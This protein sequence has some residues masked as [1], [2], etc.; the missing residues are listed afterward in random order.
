MNYQ[1]TDSGLAEA[2]PAVA[3]I[4]DPGFCPAA[5]ATRSFQRALGP[6]GVPIELAI[7][8]G[9]GGVSRWSTRVAAPSSGLAAQN[10]FQLE[11]LVKFLLWSRGGWRI[12]FHGPM[13]LG[14]QLDRHFRETGTGRFDAELMGRRIY[15]KPFEVRLLESPSDLPAAHESSAPLGRHLDGCRIGFD[16]GASDRKVAAVMEGRTVFSDE[17]LSATMDG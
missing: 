13:E 6:A 14:R 16:L 5:L 12:H 1:A 2:A 4:L 3:P 10:F 11:R 15:E 9:D 8:R 7:E 17:T